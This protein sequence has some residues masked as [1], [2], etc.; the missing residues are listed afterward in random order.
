MIENVWSVCL[1]EDGK[2]PCNALFFIIMIFLIMYFSISIA[3]CFYE[4][5]LL[6]EPK[7]RVA[8]TR[9]IA[10]ILCLLNKCFLSYYLY[11][12][13]QYKIKEITEICWTVTVHVSTIYGKRNKSNIF[14]YEKK[15]NLNLKWIFESHTL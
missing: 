10:N 4:C 13:I 6:P 11:T 15:L 14:Y 7:A 12:R 2:C 9:V 8:N 3:S 1:Y 5:V